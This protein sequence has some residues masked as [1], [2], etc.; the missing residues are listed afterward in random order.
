M[1]RRAKINGFLTTFVKWCNVI[2]EWVKCA[3][4]ICAFLFL[5]EVQARG[6]Q[7]RGGQARG[8]QA[9]GGQARKGFLFMERILDKGE[10]TEWMAVQYHCW[11]PCARKPKL[12]SCVYLNLYIYINIYIYMYCIK[13][14]WSNCCPQV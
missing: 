10:L 1:C 13:L 12:I 5:N 11:H 4:N 2:E 8:G 3:A 7:A 6:G 9:R 14:L